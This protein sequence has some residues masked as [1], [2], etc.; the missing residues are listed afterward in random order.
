VSRQALPEMLPG[1][2]HLRSVRVPSATAYTYSPVTVKTST[3]TCRRPPER[4]WPHESEYQHGPCVGSAASV[5]QPAP[6]D[7]PAGADGCVAPAG[8]RIPRAGYSGV[9]RDGPSASSRARPVVPA[10]SAVRY[11]LSPRA[12]VE[13]PPAA[14]ARAVDAPVAAPAGRQTLSPGCRTRL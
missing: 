7:E 6:D 10:R 14:S 8:S 12:I 5:A 4:G 9:S 11:Q 3:P 13:S 2:A 1:C